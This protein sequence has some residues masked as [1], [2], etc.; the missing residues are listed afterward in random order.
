MQQLPSAVRSPTCSLTIGDSEMNDLPSAVRSAGTQS[1]PD[2]PRAESA[3]LTGALPSIPRQNGY[4]LT[5]LVR[6][7]VM[8]S[9]GPTY[10]VHQSQRQPS[11][12]VISTKDPLQDLVPQGTSRQ[13]PSMLIAE[14]VNG[15]AS[16]CRC[17]V[18]HPDVHAH[19]RHGQWHCFQMP[20][21]IS[22]NARP[23]SLPNQSRALLLDSVRS[24]C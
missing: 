7:S 1:R 23:C 19:C 13:R 4:N 20:M 8:P 16:K 14:E 21:P 15:T 10:P 18:R 17:R 6:R 5:Y 22:H 11:A 3:K 12:G 9:L 24:P 2:L